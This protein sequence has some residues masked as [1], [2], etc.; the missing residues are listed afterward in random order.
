MRIA[1]Y[2]TMWMSEKVFLHR[3]C[4]VSFWFR[5]IF[6]FGFELR[7]WF[8][9]SPS[10]VLIVRYCFWQYTGCKTEEWIFM[11]RGR[12]EPGPLVFVSLAFR[13]KFGPRPTGW[14]RPRSVI[15]GFSYWRTINFSYYYKHPSKIPSRWIYSWILRLFRVRVRG[16]W[17]RVFLCLERM[18]A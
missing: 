17:F 12:A 1:V 18:K 6:R 4:Y 7:F 13:K 16:L 5:R 3:P 11:S 14:G 2:A 8:L 15:L 9:I 10:V